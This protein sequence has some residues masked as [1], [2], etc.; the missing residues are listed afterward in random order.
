MLPQDL[1]SYFE[2]AE[3]SFYDAAY[4]VPPDTMHLFDND[5]STALKLLA[6]AAEA[7]RRAYIKL[8]IS[9]KVLDGADNSRP[10]LGPESLVGNCE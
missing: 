2:E 8:Y 6:E 5:V 4:E 3:L 1:Q 7:A 9:Q 10:T